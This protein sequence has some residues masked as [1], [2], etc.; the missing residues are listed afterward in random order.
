V[1]S[2]ANPSF[3][4]KLYDQFKKKK[5]SLNKVTKEDILD[6]YGSCAGEWLC[7]AKLTSHF[8]YA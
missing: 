2:Q 4:E 1:L 7:C 8:I 5:S 3:S 6:K